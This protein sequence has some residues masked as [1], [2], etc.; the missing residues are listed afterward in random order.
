MHLIFCSN[1]N[2]YFSILFRFSNLL[3]KTVW[4]LCITFG[5]PIFRSPLCQSLSFTPTFFNITF[6]NFLLTEEMLRGKI[7][8]YNKVGTVSRP[9]PRP[10]PTGLHGIAVAGVPALFCRDTGAYRLPV[11]I[12]MSGGAFPSLTQVIKPMKKSGTKRFA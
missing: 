2:L 1:Q 6:L 7:P 12:F 5:T 4:K 10:V 3:W 8:W 9:H 11:F